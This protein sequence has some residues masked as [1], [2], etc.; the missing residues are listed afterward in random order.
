MKPAIELVAH[1]AVERPQKSGAA[2]QGDPQGRGLFQRPRDRRRTEIGGMHLEA[3]QRQGYRLG[4]D[5]AGGVQHALCR[6]RGASAGAD[7]RAEDRT[8]PPHLRPPVAVQGVVLVGHAV[9]EVLYGVGLVAA[10]LR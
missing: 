1:R 10:S 2:G 9:V 6:G 3:G 4:A 5:A 7:E 8:L